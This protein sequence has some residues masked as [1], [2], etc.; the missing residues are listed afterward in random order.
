[1]SEGVA[2]PER[3]S[4]LHLRYE[5]Q[6][7]DLD[8]VRRIVTV[9]GVFRR[10]EVEVAV[11]L[12]E[13][14]LAKGARCGYEFIF[15]ERDGQTIGY[16]CFGHIACTVGCYDLYWLAVTPDEQRC[17]VGRL[18]LAEVEKTLCRQSARR[19]YIETSGGSS[20]ANSRDFY[21]RCGYR[22]AA[23]LSDFYAPG[24]AKIIYEKTF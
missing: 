7:D 9:T 21:E 23:T 8:S 2:R 3:E 1:M 15:A 17:G 5:P 22:R 18:L 6:A 10:A 4:R 24:D 19:L 12:V 14:R 11:E 20:Y 16:A 13:E